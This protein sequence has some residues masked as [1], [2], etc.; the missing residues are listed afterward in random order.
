[1]IREY[2]GKPRN[3]DG[4]VGIEHYPKQA[5]RIK[6]CSR[7]ATKKVSSKNSRYVYHCCDEC[8]IK[9][10]AKYGD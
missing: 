10:Q 5:P 4:Y 9:I 3:C 6:R 7:L 2:K 1:M 8:A